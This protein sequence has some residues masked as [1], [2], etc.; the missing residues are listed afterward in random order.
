M[1]DW[2]EVEIEVGNIIWRIDRISREG[3][4]KI[5]ATKISNKHNKTTATQ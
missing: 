2:K 1:I 5:S 4:Q 3:A